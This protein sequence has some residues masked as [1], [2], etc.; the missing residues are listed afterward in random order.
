MRFVFPVGGFFLLVG[1]V[2]GCLLTQGEPL[3]VSAALAEEKGAGIPDFMEVVHGTK[4]ILSQVRDLLAGDGPAD[5]KAWKAV[6][7]RASILLF[8][9]DT[10]LLKSQPSKGD[11]ASWKEKVADYEQLAKALA[12]AAAG[13]DPSA[14]KSEVNKISKSCNACHKAHK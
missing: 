14:A 7:A 3:P 12:R 4:G 5:E 1:V 11:K 13:K 10:I 9:T 6:K 2:L 8:L